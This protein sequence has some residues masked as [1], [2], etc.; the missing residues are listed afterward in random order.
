MR[1]CGDWHS[2]VWGNTS[3]SPGPR[4]SVRLW[5]R[6]SGLGWPSPPDP[7]SSLPRKRIASRLLW[8]N[9]SGVPVRAGQGPGPEAEAT[10]PRAAAVSEA[11]A[12]GG[13]WV[14]GTVCHPS[15]SQPP[16][17]S[18]TGQTSEGGGG[19]G[20]RMA[21]QRPPTKEP[22][23]EVVPDHTRGF[24]LTLGLGRGGPMPPAVGDER[25]RLHRKAA[26]GR[27]QDGSAG[28]WNTLDC[29]KGVGIV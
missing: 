15:S 3:A 22:P 14:D 18:S 5:T 23:M 10:R 21:L 9:N 16:A 26:T 11:G 7:D 19:W 1:S 13:L 12:G 2:K 27:G 20:P 25:L 4:P 28:H 29:L 6:Q 8:H 17:W 24:L